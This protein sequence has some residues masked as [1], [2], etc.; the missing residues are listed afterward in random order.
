MSR[1]DPLLGWQTRGLDTG[2]EATFYKDDA[3]RSGLVFP[4][5][6]GQGASWSLIAD[7]VAGRSQSSEEARARLA[8]AL[9]AELD[10]KL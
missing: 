9:P 1:S 6:A 10:A 8:A 7:S 2:G 5:G 4:A 3:G